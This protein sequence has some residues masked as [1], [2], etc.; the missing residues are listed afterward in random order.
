MQTKSR[1]ELQPHD[2]PITILLVDD[3][4]A[5]RKGV[6]SLL[7]TEPNL[8]V[9]G[10]VNSGEE[11]YVWYRSHQPQVVVMDLSMTGFGGL[12]SIRRILRF[13]SSARIL[14]YSVHATNVMLKRA[15]AVGALGYVT[16]GSNTDVLINGIREVA[17][18]R[19]FVSPDMISLLVEDHAANERPLI[20]RLGNREFEIFLLT[21]QGEMPKACAQTLNI[22]EKTVRNQLTQIKLKL[23]VANT[24]DL[25][26]LAIRAGLVEP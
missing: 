13:N 6:H 16:K 2:G 22:S 3:H 10:E 11:A 1:S 4:P 26:R 14:V 24:A 19:G 23:K 17:H 7:S 21:V 18:R 20:N 8:V 5:L 25:T 9:V 15:L 12:E